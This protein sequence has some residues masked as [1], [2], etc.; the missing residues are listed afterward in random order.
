MKKS[1]RGNLKYFPVLP[2]LPE[3]RGCNCQPGGVLA[4][5]GSTSPSICTEIPEQPLNCPCSWDTLGDVWIVC[6]RHQCLHV[7]VR[8]SSMQVQM[9][10]CV[11]SQ[12]VFKRNKY[13]LE[14]C[15]I[16]KIIFKQ[17]LA[18][19]TF[20]FFLFCHRASKWHKSPGT[21]F[22]WDINHYF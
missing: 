13:F 12:Q 5:A 15:S 17:V 1:L 16:F 19:K 8:M 4:V 11:E 14:Y 18:I 10:E 2:H 22:R 20:F 7:W 6:Y 21:A 9:N 3:V